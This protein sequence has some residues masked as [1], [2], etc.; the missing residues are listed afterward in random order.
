M[1]GDAIGRIGR[2][3]FPGRA[4]HDDAEPNL[5]PVL[6]EAQPDQVEQAFLIDGQRP[7]LF[8]STAFCFNDGG[9]V[10]VMVS[11][12]CVGGAWS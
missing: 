1:H 10:S 6:L 3:H 12:S 5:V 8:P 11:P 9:L 7:T 4:L 2:R